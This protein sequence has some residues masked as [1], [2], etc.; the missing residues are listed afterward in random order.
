MGHFLES[1]RQAVAA[2]CMQAGFETV[3]SDVLEILTHMINSY[4]LELGNTTRQ[5]TELAGR[6]VS[7]PHD[8]VM[9]LIELGTRVMDLPLFLNDCSNH[10]TLVI[11]PPK[12]PPIVTT[13]NA[14]RVG[15]TRFH[16]SFFSDG[17]PA[18]PD[19]HTYIRT[20]ISGEPELTYEKVR[21]DFANLKR[22][23]EY[24]LKDFML[25]I[26]PSVSLFNSFENMLRRQA[27]QILSQ[28]I[29]H[30]STRILEEKEIKQESL[31]GIENNA[32]EPVDSFNG[33]EI[34]LENSFMD[35]STS[36][37]AISSDPFLLDD[38]EISLIRKK[39]PTYCQIIE[40]NLDN[41]PYFGASLCDELGED[42]AEMSSPELNADNN[43]V[44]NNAPV[45]EE[46]VQDVNPYLQISRMAVLNR[47]SKELQ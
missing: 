9:A 18:L 35:C 10:G 19:P 20:E 4:L 45:D 16:Q 42:H 44:G 29:L 32:V 43:M 11:G 47:D 34:K 30:G 28:Q 36:I 14:L 21:D 8:A 1:L 5:L 25:R 46:T 37:S 24:S 17:L 7:T 3:E 12:L 2:M 33:T 23:S 39:L 22:N 6:T 31:N 41:R 26:H 38:T 15:A 27:K 40:S 13:P